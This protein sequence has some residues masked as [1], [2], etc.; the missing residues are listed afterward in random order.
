GEGRRGDHPDHHGQDPARGDP[1][2]RLPGVGGRPVQQGEQ[3]A[4]NQQQHRPLGDLPDPDRG[5]AEPQQSAEKSG[6][7]PGGH[8]RHR[9]GGQQH[10]DDH[11][12]PDADGQG[13]PDRPAPGH[14]ATSWM[15][16]GARMKAAMYGEPSYNAVAKLTRASSPAE[17]RVCCRFVIAV[18]RIWLTEPGTT[19]PR[20]ANSVWM[21]PEP[22]RSTRE[23]ST[24]RAGKIDSTL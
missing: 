15:G 12:D 5:G 3:K 4:H 10:H 20:L 9:G 2:K 23:I 22:A 13:L 16:W 11:G 14:R 24:S 17:P 8:H 1:A 7:A 18:A 6:Q 19:W 21:V